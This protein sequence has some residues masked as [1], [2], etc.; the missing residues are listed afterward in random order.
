MSFDRLFFYFFVFNFG[1]LRIMNTYQ[2]MGNRIPKDFFVTQGSG[3]SDITLHAGSFHLALKEA[4][5]E[6]ANIISYSSI[7]PGIARKIEKPETYVHGE[8]METILAV[9]NCRRGERAAAGI[10]I[11]WL[12]D[13]KTGEIIGGLVCER[14]GNY[15]IEELK[16]ELNKSLM[17][18]YMNG[19][20][21]NYSIKDIDIMTE[22]ITPEKEYGTA[23]VAICFVN[24]LYPIISTN[25]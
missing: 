7:M 18:L 6:R 5:I 21:D 20:E 1:W 22:T 8:V 16:D 9:S 19:F 2:V 25:E 23:L 11:G 15:S 4:G 13:D 12:E 24:Y 10:I 17:E 14:E 3:E